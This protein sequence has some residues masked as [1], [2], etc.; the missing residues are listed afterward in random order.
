MQLGNWRLDA[1]WGHLAFATV[2][3]GIT[4]WYFQDVTGTSMNRN[5]IILVY[6]LSLM[7]LGLYGVTLIK[8]IR[9]HRTAGDADTTKPEPDPAVAAE[10]D[11][12]QTNEQEQ[13][14]F[15]MVRA[16]ILLLMLGGFV[17]SYNIIGLDVATFVFIALSL[18][19]LGYRRWWF[20]LVYALVFTV[21][22][23]G[24]ARFLLSYPMPT[25]FL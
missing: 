6:P 19:L 24:G 9:I 20:V 1:D 11:E 15:D 7:I 17:F 13:S 14:L 12:P 3:A 23:I 5:N 18:V 25:L 16:L 8:S 22:V 10:D 2:I 4:W 21:F